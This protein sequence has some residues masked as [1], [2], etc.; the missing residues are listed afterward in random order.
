VA[1]TVPPH[2]E[3]PADAVVHILQRPRPVL[4]EELGL[5]A[6]AIHERAQAKHVVDGEDSVES[7]RDPILGH[8]AVAILGPHQ[9][10]NR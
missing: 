10:A 1:V 9:P 8:E 6:V 3:Q 4:V 7:P 2:P 5:V